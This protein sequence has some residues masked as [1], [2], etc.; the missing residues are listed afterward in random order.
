MAVKRVIDTGF[1]NDDKVVENFT[2]E[3]KLFMLY[4][5]TNPHTTQLGIYAINKKTMAFE[6]GYSTD[7]INNLLDRFENNYKMIMF[8]TETNEIAIKNYLRHSIVKGGK[9]VEDC[10]TKE[11]SQVKDKKLLQ[12]V[13]SNLVNYENLNETVNSILNKYKNI[14]LLNNN[15]NDNEYS[16]P[17]SWDDT[18]NDTSVEIVDN[19][20][21]IKNNIID[22]LNKKTGSNY[23]FS[24]KKTNDLINTRLKE[25]FTEQD[26]YEVIDKKTIEWKGTDFEK[27]LRPETLFSNKFESYLNQKVKLDTGVVMRMKGIDL[28]KFNFKGSEKNE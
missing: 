28:T 10:L 26:F 21:G 15:D 23:K 25:G 27:F 6:L 17:L 7:T 9:P 24:S 22:Y 1:W 19:K 16:Y 3:D 20:Q 12:Y 11:I 5:L 4:L 2:P 14:I 18:C 8:S 13:F